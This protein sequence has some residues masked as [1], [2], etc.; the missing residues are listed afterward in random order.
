MPII[1]LTTDFGTADGY[2]G[3]MKGV[4]LNE[5]PHADVVDVTHDI[6]AQD[7]EAGAWCL[8]S[9]W[10]YYPEGTLHVA[11]VDPGVGTDRQ[12]VIAEVDGRYLIGPDNGLFTHP[13]QR[14]EQREVRR[15][16]ADFHL[17]AHLSATFHGRDI[18]AYAAGVIASGRMDWK[19]IAE[20]AEEFVLLAVSQ[21]EYGERI[22]KGRILHVDRYGNLITNIEGAR[23]PPDAQWTMRIGGADLSIRDIA[24]TYGDV[25]QGR[26]VAVIGSSGFLEIA[27]CGGS[28]FRVFQTDPGTP[29]AL[30]RLVYE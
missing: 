2:V 20:P 25:D 3:A 11:V 15:I 17:P 7:V 30:K 1:T 27:V 4:I 24:R 8:A 19:E 28:A 6:P 12:A 29:V 22:I 16:K 26:P 9:C 23:L 10:R 5:A 21:P 13:L 18:F 14:A